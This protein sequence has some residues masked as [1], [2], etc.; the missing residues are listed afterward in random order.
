LAL[1][2]PKHVKRFRGALPEDDKCDPRDSHLINRYCQVNGVRHPYHPDE[3]YLPLRQLTRAY[4]RLIHTLGAEK[5]FCLSVLYLLASEYDRLKPFA[6][7]FGVASQTV[8]SDY[9][10][11]AVLADLPLTELAATLNGFASGRLPQPERNA[12]VLQQVAAD[13]YPLP[14]SLRPTAH[15][16]LRCTLEHI[17]FLEGQQRQYRQ[18][19]EAE[20]A[21]LPEAAMA[22]DFKGLGPILVGGCLAEIQDTTRFTTGQKYDRQ[23]HRWR[24]RTYEDG[25]AGVARLAGLWWPRHSSGRFEGE[26]RH[27]A[28]ERNSYLRFWLIQT[29]YS[30]KGHQDEYAAYYQSKYNE[31]P[32]HKHKRAIVLTARKAVRL[33]F[34]LLHKGRMRWLEEG[35]SV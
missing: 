31:T 3:R 32:K 26:E 29:A 35:V 7:T 23:R 13:S 19:I 6:D 10:D 15:T 21:Q 16:V 12:A 4:C 30:L 18:L 25:Q 34:A 8:L 9:P 5:A 27:L 20:L 14:A 11:L 33:V 2:N 28:H 1:L 17:R 22:L 24:D